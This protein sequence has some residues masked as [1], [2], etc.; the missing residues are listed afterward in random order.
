M[1]EIKDFEQKY[2]NKDVQ[3]FDKGDTILV[4]LKIKEEGKTRIQTFEGIVIGKKGSGTKATF[5]VRRIS[6]GEGVER[7]FQLNSPYIESIRVKK[8]G[9]VRRSKL[10][11]LRE[12]KGKRSK[13]AEKL[14]SDT[15]QAAKEVSGEAKT[16]KTA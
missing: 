11:Y 4:D 16:D 7:V 12:R 2:L 15:A 14:E 1:E 9:S 5:T 3:K 13:V 10:Y 6:Y 8:K